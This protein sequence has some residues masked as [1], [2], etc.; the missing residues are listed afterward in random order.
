M[1]SIEF[2]RSSRSSSLF[3]H[4]SSSSAN[5]GRLIDQSVQL[6]HV[7]FD[8]IHLSLQIVDLLRSIFLCGVET[9]FV[10]YAL[11]TRWSPVFAILLLDALPK[12]VFVVGRKI[13]ACGAV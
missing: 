10:P 12:G 13:A 6:G 7:S 8:I 3:S 1:R 2:H 4:S 5:S 9:T 11:L